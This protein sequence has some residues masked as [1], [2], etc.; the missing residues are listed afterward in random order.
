MIV[1]SVFYFFLYR[2][3]F[4]KCILYILYVVIIYMLMS[5]K[6]VSLDHSCLYIITRLELFNRSMA[7]YYL[8]CELLIDNE[9]NYEDVCIYN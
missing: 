9:I 4:S 2:I 7:F 3:H 6:Q 8:K 1:F 5:A